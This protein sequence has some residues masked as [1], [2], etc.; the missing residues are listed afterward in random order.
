MQP[1][2]ASW[3]RVEGSNGSLTFMR[4]EINSSFANPYPTLNPANPYIFE[5]V[6]RRNNI[7]IPIYH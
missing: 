6:L 4:L 2:A 3:A 7:I 1:N 5:K